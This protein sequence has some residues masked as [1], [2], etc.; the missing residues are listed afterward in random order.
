MGRPLNARDK[1][2][3]RNMWIIIRAIDIDRQ[4]ANPRFRGP[5][6]S[7]GTALSR[8]FQ[9]FP[10]TLRLPG[11][12]IATLNA[13]QAY[14]L[15]RNTLWG[16]HKKS[17]N[18]G[19]REGEPKSD[20]AHFWTDGSDAWSPEFLRELH[21]VAVELSVDDKL[22]D[23]ERLA[24]VTIP[25]QDIDLGVAQD[26][27]EDVVHCRRR[28][29]KRRLL[30]ASDDDEIT[31]ASEASNVGDISVLYSTTNM[32]TAQNLDEERSAVCDPRAR[33]ATTALTLPRE[34]AVRLAS[35]FLASPNAG[36]DSIPP[37]YLYQGLVRGKTQALRKTTRDAVGQLFDALHFPEG[38]PRT[39]AAPLGLAKTAELT[40]LYDLIWGSEWQVANCAL[41]RRGQRSIN[42]TTVSLVSAFLSKHVTDNDAL[43][44]KRTN[45]MSDSL[46]VA[47]NV[48]VKGILDRHTESLSMTF[49]D[50]FTPYISGLLQQRDLQNILDQPMVSDLDWLSACSTIVL[51]IIASALSLKQ[52]LINSGIKFEF[53]WPAHGAD[54]QPTCM[55]TFHTDGRS[56]EGIHAAKVLSAR[57]PGLKVALELDEK[58]ETH[59]WVKADVLLNIPQTSDEVSS[60]FPT[61]ARCKASSLRSIDT[62][63]PDFAGLA[64]WGRFYHLML[65]YK[66]VLINISLTRPCRTENHQ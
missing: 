52:Y 57:F 58:M 37:P 47:N 34:R 41:E 11:G 50:V 9:N 54:W 39:G 30:A 6:S 53:F 64:W 66:A 31:I 65:C 62:S 17:R 7:T 13:G 48:R 46:N 5:P 25:P 56:E 23:V 63:L 20:F 42:A 35:P 49:C 38:S 44:G 14:S 22:V 15:A 61:W 36:K 32:P 8:Y 59:C 45:M 27:V 18:A 43:L 1:S 12:D 10:N 26:D 16:G 2:A 21:H 60:S 33:R 40:S 19:Y 24:P 29:R 3:R 55:A 28:G 4:S 51:P